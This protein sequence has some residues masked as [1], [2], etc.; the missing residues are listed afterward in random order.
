[1]I[2]LIVLIR[3]LENT[4][5]LEIVHCHLQM[6]LVLLQISNHFEEDHKRSYEHFILS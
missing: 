2:I 6:I 4:K 3:E 5:H 1:M